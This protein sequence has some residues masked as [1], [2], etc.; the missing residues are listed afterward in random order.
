[1]ETLNRPKVTNDGNM[2]NESVF[3]EQREKRKKADDAFP[4]AS[5]K[6]KEP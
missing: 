5:Q 4:S 2:W 3:G 1:M 6:V